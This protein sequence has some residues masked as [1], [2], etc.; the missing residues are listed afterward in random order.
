MIPPDV[1][2]RAAVMG[3]DIMA[4]CDHNSCENAAPF[5]AAGRK[6]NVVVFPGMEVCTKEEAHI[7]GLF[8]SLEAAMSLQDLVYAHIEGVNDEDAFG[9]QAVVNEKGDPIS[10]NERLL[11]GATDLSIENVVDAI[12]AYNGVA[13]ASH[14]DRESF[15]II[16]QLGFIPEHLKLD[17]LE[18]SGHVKKEEHATWQREFVQI[19]FVRGSDAHC[20]EEVGQCLTTLIMNAPTFEEF[21]KALLGEEGR[22]IADA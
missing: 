7:L 3:I 9:I 12:H 1:M 13:I 11:I 19:P 17:A 8:D 22:G 20:L 16:G 5:I 2:K 6:G 14:I 21:K 15:S 18:L 10:I 4:I